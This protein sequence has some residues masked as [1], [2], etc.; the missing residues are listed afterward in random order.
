MCH[1][2][3]LVGSCF[4]LIDSQRDGGCSEQ[5]RS[6]EANLKENKMRCFSQILTQTLRSWNVKSL[7]I[8]AVVLVV[9][10]G[11]FAMAQ[12]QSGLSTIQGT[13]TDSTG[14][15]IP[16]ATIHIVNKATAAATDAKSNGAGFYQ[17]PGL[18]AGAY[19]VTVQ[20]SGMKTYVYTLNL[21]A[22]QTAVVNPVMAVGAVT[23]KVTVSA[24]MVQ[25]TNTT[26]GSITTTLE[27][28]QINHIPMNG[29]NIS[30]LTW[31]TTPGLEPGLG[32]GGTRMNDLPSEALEYV[33][34]GA[35]TLNRDFGGPNSTSQS[36]YTDADSV[37]E[38][39]VEASGGGAQYATPGTAIITTKSGIIIRG[40]AWP[41]S[42]L[43]SLF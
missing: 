11:T 42:C 13:V 17:A 4:R 28:D 12:T 37:Q 27:N 18:V 6:G 8:V 2:E 3:M 1:I 30:Y 5:I 40:R 41:H 9:L 26:D 21:L 14:A 36:Q 22:T 33:E 43:A 7:S 10:C 24:S 19:T 38:V 35:P 16:G 31:Y 23:E 39:R 25:L 34:D 15:L 32:G 29:R 20:A